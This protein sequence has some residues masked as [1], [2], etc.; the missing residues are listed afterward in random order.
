MILNALCMPSSSDASSILLLPS[1][2]L[3]RS[4]GF[5]AAITQQVHNTGSAGETRTFANSI[6][7]LNGQ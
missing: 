6:G 4:Q 5:I 2:A 1:V 3:V 7:L